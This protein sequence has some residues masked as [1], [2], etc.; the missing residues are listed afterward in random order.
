MRTCYCNLEMF[1]FRGNLTQSREMLLKDTTP[2]NTTA[3]IFLLE[4]TLNAETL[5]LAIEDP[6]RATIMIELTI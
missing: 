1:T 6:N 4:K 3:S 5:F 2:T